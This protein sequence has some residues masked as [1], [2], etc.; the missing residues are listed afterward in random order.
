[1][2]KLISLAL[3]VSLGML[4]IFTSC[5][6]EEIT[7]D[8]LP[9]AT[10]IGEVHANL[11]ITNT[12]LESAPAGTKIFFRINSQQLALDPLPGYNY[13]TL[14]YETTVDANGDYS[15]TLPCVAH[16]NVAVTI[17]LD[18][19]RYDVVTGAGDVETYFNGTQQTQGIRDGET[20]YLDL[21][22]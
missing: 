10:I 15:I 16:Q 4:M 6:K 22:Y 3:I 17:T 11:D 21:F 7:A 2:K 20:H 13:Q 8:P 12:S 1:M 5:K 14:Q 18:D 9:T 19:L